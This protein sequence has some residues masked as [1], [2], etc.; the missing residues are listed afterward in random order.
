ME[1]FCK[2]IGLPEEAIREVLRW[3]DRWRWDISGL[4][5]P[6]AWEDAR[7]RLR[8]ELGDDPRGFGELCAMLRCAQALWSRYGALGIPR[9][10]YRDTM[11][12]FSRFVRE[13]RESFG[14]YGFDRGFWT[15]RQV[16][17]L[18]FRI[19]TLEYELKG[20]QV[21]LHIPSDAD[22]TPEMVQRSLSRARAFLAAHFPA[23]AQAPMTCHSWLLS[24]VLGE[25]LPEGSRI[26]SFQRLFSVEPVPDPGESYRLWVFKHPGLDPRDFPEHTTLQ[27]SL[28]A[29]V[30][31][32][33]PVP[34]GR[35]VLL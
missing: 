1:A 22:L 11:A 32:G 10:I 7:E 4:M 2:E 30:L 31:R 20:S 19:G 23:Y 26:L 6:N 8:R 3:N 9:E 5:D 14:V 28:K 33:N 16:S 25:L 21:A 18:L 35:G 34:Q 15:V 13:H 27:R 12:C 29:Y 24:P 17:G